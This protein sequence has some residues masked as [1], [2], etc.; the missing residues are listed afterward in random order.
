MVGSRN[1]NKQF[2]KLEQYNM[3]WIKYYTSIVVGQV[4]FSEFSSLEENEM[5]ISFKGV[6]VKCQAILSEKEVAI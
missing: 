3:N 6:E 4:W 5:T 1:K 2:N